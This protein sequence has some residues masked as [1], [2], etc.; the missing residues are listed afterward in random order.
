MNTGR[1]Y[2]FDASVLSAF[3][4]VA[5][6]ELLEERYTG[7]ATW[8]AEVFDELARGIGSHPSLSSV[9]T[10]GWL[11][12]PNQSFDVVLV[13][14]IRRALG[15]K[16][17]HPYRHLGEAATLAAA[18]NDGY[19]VAIDDY[20]ATRYARRQGVDT[21]NTIAILRALTR[22]GLLTAAA[23]VDLLTEMI[24]RHGRRLPSLSEADFTT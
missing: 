11:G 8:T 2:I 19:I 23:A 6:L 20:D 10:A 3:A 14:R 12:P 22:D 18:I 1:C 7:R 15:G 5:Q 24:D 16:A 4:L 17:D 13:E 21:I 9:L